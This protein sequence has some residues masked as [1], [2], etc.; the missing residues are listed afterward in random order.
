MGGTIRIRVANSSSATLLLNNTDTQLSLENTGGNMIFTTAGAAERMRIN[1]TGLVGIGTSFSQTRLQTN[2]A[3]T[4]SYLGY[5]NG[6]ASTFDMSA[7]IATVHNSPSIGT[8]TAAGLVLANNDKSDGAP[9]PIIAFSAKS[10]SNTYNH[11]YAAIYGIRTATGADTN[12][13]KGDIVLATGQSTGPIERMR[14]NSIGNVGIGTSGFAQKRLDI[15]GPTGGQVLITGASDAVG[16]TAGIMFRSEASEENGLARVKGGIFFERIAGTYGNGKLKFAVNSS[17]NNDTVAVS[18]VAITIDTNKNVGIGTTSPR[19]LL[20]VG[21]STLTG[22]GS[23]NTTAAFYG[24]YSDVYSQVGVYDNDATGI[25][26]G[27]AIDFGGLPG[28]TSSSPY[29][30]GKIGA[31][32]ENATVGDYAG[33][34]QLFTTSAGSNLDFARLS[35]NSSGSIKFDSYSSTSQTGTPTYLLGT[36]A[37]GNVVKTLSTPSPITSQAASLY[38]LIPNGAFTTTYAFTS[39]AGTYAEVMS[40]DDVITATGTYSVQMI[41]NDYAVGGTQYDEK[42][43]G[44]MSWHAGSTNDSGIG[45]SSE[46]VLHRAGHAGNQGITYLRTRETAAAGN[47]ELKLEIMCNRTYTGASNVIFKFVRLI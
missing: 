13:T 43:S 18:D 47:N 40:G 1:S 5:L 7:N 22:S 32:K 15:S 31:F 16:T 34:L 33:Y 35:I 14:I 28:G 39:T 41:V 17:A 37:S 6:T 42:Y 12:W 27:G 45:A 2:L 23:T 30:F 11:T 26:V 46:I 20:Q 38:D 3:I 19:H 8:G 29:P 4:G 25:G 24:D 9:S 44:V 10:A 36:D 21:A